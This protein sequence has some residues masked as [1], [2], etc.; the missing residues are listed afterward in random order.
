MLAPRA[1]CDADLK[2]SRSS[3]RRTDFGCLFS[4]IPGNTWCAEWCTTVCKEIPEHA[5]TFAASSTPV[6]YPV[7]TSPIRPQPEVSFKFIQETETR[8]GME[9]GAHYSTSA[10]GRRTFSR[11]NVS[12]QHAEGAD[13]KRDRISLLQTAGRRCGQRL[14][15]HHFAKG[16]CTENG[17]DKCQRF[18]SLDPRF[19]FFL[20]LLLCFFFFFTASFLR[21][22]WPLCFFLP[23]S[24]EEDELS[25]LHQLQVSRRSRQDR[26][27]TGFLSTAFWPETC[28]GH[29]QRPGC[30]RGHRQRSVTANFFTQARDV[31]QLQH[32][33][34]RR[35]FAFGARFGCLDAVT[36]LVTP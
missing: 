12:S 29:S 14:I 17:R 25:E 11:H 3:S 21:D 6:P 23:S 35:D 30:R 31:R 20:S 15:S 7:L 22:L 9:E 18:E 26:A 16:C 34:E 27:H 13:M 36:E 32:V 28:R 1:A 24:L 8:R 10:K 33:L 5:A 19:F 2:T 4:L